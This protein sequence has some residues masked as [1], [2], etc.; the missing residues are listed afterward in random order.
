V[1][2]SDVA[3]IGSMAPEV[4]VCYAWHTTGI[5]TWD[6]LV[7]RKETVF[8]STAKGTA[9]YMNASMLRRVF[10][11]K[12]RHVLGFPGSAEQKLA[13]ERGELDAD[14]GSWSSLPVEWI[15]DKKINPIVSFSPSRES[16]MPADIPYAGKF[17]KTPDQQALLEIFAASSEVGRPF[18]MSKAVPQDRIETVRKAFDASLKDPQLLADAKKLNLPIQ[19]MTGAEAEKI[20]AHVYQA[21]PE[22]IAKVREITE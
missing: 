8:G 19:G 10:D 16:S 5:K 22:S 14:C 6:D 20:I 12:I 18:I 7:A 13:L 15:A 2:F 4:R 9:N 3:W 1:R 11:I 21:S 17:A